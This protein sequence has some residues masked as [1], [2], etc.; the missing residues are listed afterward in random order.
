M[1][2]NLDTKSFNLIYN[3]GLQESKT[4]SQNSSIFWEEME[5][6]ETLVETL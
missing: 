1:K 5:E 6:M 2:L 3:L 4:S